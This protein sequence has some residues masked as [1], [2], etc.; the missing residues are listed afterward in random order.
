M[1][2][3]GPPWEGEPCADGSPSVD[4]Q[5]TYSP[6]AAGRTTVKSTGAA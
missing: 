6:S 3:N 4:L 2:H 1:K 5:N